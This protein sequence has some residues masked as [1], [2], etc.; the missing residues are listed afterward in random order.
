MV[1]VYNS[2]SH[3]HPQYYGE[4]KMSV[5]GSLLGRVANHFGEKWIAK[6]EQ[7]FPYLEAII[8]RSNEKVKIVT[9]ELDPSLYEHTLLPETIGKALERGVEFEIEMES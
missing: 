1:V 9:G 6:G 5:I 8:N 7:S 2:V 4:K 3:S